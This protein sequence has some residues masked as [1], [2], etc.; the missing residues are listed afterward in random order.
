MADQQKR[1]EIFNK[2][3]RACDTFRGVIDP[4]QYKDYILT[5]LFV[6]YL[7][8]IRKSKLAEYENR[9]QGDRIRI[10]RAMGRER[11]I[12]AENCTFD[13]LYA[14]R[15]DNDI[16]QTIN[17]V[18][19]KIED[20]NKSKLHN[21]FRN[22]DFNSEANLGQ[23][24]QRNSRLRNLLEDFVGL[25]LRPEQVGHMDV[26][27]DVY[28]YLIAKFA[29]SA[30]KKAGEFYTPAE[31][32]ETLARLVAPKSGDRICDPACGSGSLLIRTSKQ[33]GSADFSLYGQ[34][35]NGSTW[36]L[37]KMNMFLH[38]VDAARIE[39]EDTIRH[40]LLVEND[41]LMKFDVVVANPPF[42]LDKWGQ[43]IAATDKYNRFKR[44]IPPKSKGDWAFISHMLAIA[45]EG[46]GRVGVV[47][48]HGVLFRGGSEG[49]IR[50]SVI[51]ENLLDAVIGLPPNLFYGTG[52]PATLI[53][54]DKSRNPAGK[55]DVL[56]IDASHDFLQGTNQN[57]LRPQ[58]TDKIVETFRKREMVKRYSY[59]ATYAEIEENEF[60]LNIPRYVDTLEPEQE[61]DLRSVQMEIVDIESKLSQ[62]RE[63]MN[64]YL[65]ELGVFQS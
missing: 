44:G 30:G 16:G 10:E 9:Y 53:I 4:G 57:R 34:E 43:E 60:N 54:F 13:Y 29:A 21:V 33:V 41:T 25:D 17:T 23:T 31:V 36:A 52:I 14:H 42:S 8:D 15:T 26:V 12:V 27:G 35:M 46:K 48:P 32:S 58:D 19:E 7:N 45:V 6:K 28:E 40:S 24:R 63:K 5:M 51:G 37:C 20:A 59:L 2:V 49:K 50:E 18:L 11:F 55:G 64:G 22:I 38:E 47:V 61:V 1:D 62:T 56:F 3:W 65:K 39:W